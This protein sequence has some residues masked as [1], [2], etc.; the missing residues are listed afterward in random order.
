MSMRVNVESSDSRWIA[1]SGLAFVVAWVAG[2]VFVPS[3]P[4]A[5]ADP[6]EWVGYLT[7]HGGDV[8]LQVYL[9]NGLT[10]TALIIFA[11]A[12]RSALRRF[13]GASSTLS[14]VLLGGGIAAASVS[15]VQGTFLQVAANHIST[16]QD[17]AVIQTLVALNAEIDTFKFFPLAFLVGATSLLAVRTGAFT[18]WIGWLGI[19]VAGLLIIAG[20]SFPLNND[21]LGIVLYISGIGMLLWFAVVSIAMGWRK[22]L[23]QK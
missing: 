23:T 9:I 10:G 20:W 18:R 16:L 19:T 15:F 14:N 17:P 6:G 4:A 7:A 3:A 13:E 12:M 22:Q 8:M 5:N 1:V 21:N 2:L 11:A